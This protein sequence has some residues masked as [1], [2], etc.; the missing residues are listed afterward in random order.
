LSRRSELDESL[1][2]FFEKTLTDV[3]REI[4]IEKWKISSEEL[5]SD[6]EWRIEKRRLYG[7]LSDCVD[8]VEVDNGRFCFVVVPTRGMGIWKGRF[9]GVCLGW[10]SPVRSVVHPS[11]VNLEARNGLGWLDGFNEWIVR[12]GIGSFGA[13]GPDKIID[14]MGNEKEVLL[15]LHGKVANIPAD[16]V[17]ARMRL[18]PPYELSITGKVYERSMFGS[19]F[20]MD[21]EITTTPGADSIK[22]IDTV[23][24][25][26]SLPDEMQIL[27]HCNYGS[28]FLEEGSHLV[29]PIQKVVPRDPHAAEGI[30]EFDVFGPPQTGFV[31]Q[32]YFLKLIGDEKGRTSVMLANK[33]ETKAT[34]VSFS[35]EELPCFTLWKNTSSLEEGYVIGLEPGTS[36]PNSKAFERKQE[37]VVR[38]KLGENHRSEINFSVYASQA[39][40]NRAKK[41]IEEIGKGIEPEILDRPVKEFSPY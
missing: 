16:I 6:G 13:P 5:G 23:R 38:L 10:N 12:C 15:T 32:V 20:E 40:V 28:P 17:K 29:A 4:Y 3:E 8:I 9:E 39:E 18:E 14:N 25:L 19:D 35:V 41:R 37:R 27:Y 26:R 30:R 11:F 33:D 7:G 21:T 22:I 36:Y 2:G 31:E 1:R 24:N 34:S